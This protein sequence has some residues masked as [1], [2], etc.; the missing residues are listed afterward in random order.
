MEY[1]DALSSLS[2]GMTSSRL[3]YREEYELAN[4]V[5]LVSVSPA[6]AMVNAM[7]CHGL[8]A[9]PCDEEKSTSRSAQADNTEGALITTVG[10]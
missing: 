10:D 2:L 8:P 3:E 9:F 6:L 7:D 4:A 5:K 1:V